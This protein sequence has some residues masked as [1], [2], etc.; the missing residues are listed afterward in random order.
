MDPASAND[1]SAVL[2]SVAQSF[3]AVITAFNLHDANVART[4]ID[5][6][7]PESSIPLDRF[8]RRIKATVERRGVEILANDSFV[9]VG[10]RGKFRNESI[11]INRVDRVIFTKPTGITIGDRTLPVYS[12]VFGERLRRSRVFTDARVLP[13]VMRIVRGPEDS[14]HL[15]Q[16]MLNAYVFEPKNG[17]EVVS[18]VHDVVALAD[19]LQLHIYNV[20]GTLLPPEFVALLPVANRW[21]IGDDVQRDDAIREARVEDLRDLVAAVKPRLNEI[22]AFLN[23]TSAPSA[24][25][26]ALGTLA[27]CALEAESYLAG[28]IPPGNS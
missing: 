3:N 1:S 20:E 7:A 16:N 28:E 26:A 21:C 17:A 10:A 19:I 5:P 6:S 12:D 22:D 18:V 2:R 8:T 11:S 15:Y 25:A 4:R 24:E 27:E 9:R 23:R 13:L 14:V